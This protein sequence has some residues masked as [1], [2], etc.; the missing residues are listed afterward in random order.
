M[1]MKNLN[2]NQRINKIFSLINKYMPSNILTNY[3][4]KYIEMKEKLLYDSQ[5]SKEKDDIRG[6]KII[7]VY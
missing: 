5:K 4:H 3:L 1:V 2:F 6:R 7:P